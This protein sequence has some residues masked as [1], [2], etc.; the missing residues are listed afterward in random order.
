MDSGMDSGEGKCLKFASPAQ[1]GLRCRAGGVA[2]VACFEAAHELQLLPQTASLSRAPG[3]VSAKRG[4][5]GAP[6]GAVPARPAP[7]RPP[8]KASQEQAKNRPR[9]GQE[10]HAKYMPP[11]LS[12]TV[13]ARFYKTICGRGGLL[14]DE[15]RGQLEARA[16]GMQL[17]LH[18]RTAHCNYYY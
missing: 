5:Y 18:A 11:S 4:P 15:M 7:V 2:A 17:H 6:S 14:W 13:P 9:T 1:H 16:Q 12:T 8:K 10:V 3:D